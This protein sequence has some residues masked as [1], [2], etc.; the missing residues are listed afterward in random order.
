MLFLITLT[1]IDMGFLIKYLIIHK[2]TIY[3]V[4]LY[5]LVT[6]SIQHLYLILMLVLL[7]NKNI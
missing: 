1:L 5:R 2:T 6:F 7:Y 3:T 4:T